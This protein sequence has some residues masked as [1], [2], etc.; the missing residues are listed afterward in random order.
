MKK[1]VRLSRWKK[2][3]IISLSA[4]LSFILIVMP[5]ATVVIYESIFGFRFETEE[6]LKYST[7]DFDGL[8]CERSDFYSTDGTR[9]AGYKYSKE[10]E[11]VKGV[12]VV[13]HGLGGGGHI[14]IAGAQLEDVTLEEANR[15][16][17]ESIDQSLDE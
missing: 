17:K 8:I 15:L 9:L 10:A 16:L 13:A 4:L 11:S 1:N 12:V 3:L 2:A 14:T 5:V 7:E 6:W